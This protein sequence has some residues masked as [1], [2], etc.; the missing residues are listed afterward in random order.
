MIVGYIL[1]FSSLFVIFWAMIGYESSL[2]ILYA[3]FKKRKKIK[4]LTIKNVKVTLMI[5]AH[6]E[7]KVIKKKLENAISIK[8]PKEMLEILVTSDNSTD[9]TN[10]IILDFIKENPN[11]NIRL[12]EVKERKGKTNAQNEA[13]KTVNSEILV[14]TDANAMFDENAI[15]EL[16]KS[17]ED[18]NI[19]YVCGQL[20]YSNEDENVASKSESMYWKREL[21]TRYIESEL[22]TI[23]SGNGAIYACRND[24]YI[25]FD[26]IQSHDSAMPKHF[27]LNKMRAIYNPDA[28]AYEKAGESYQDEFKRKVRMN[29]NIIKNLF[30]PLKVLNFFKYGW[31]TYFYLGHRTTRSNLAISHIILLVTNIIL[32]INNIYFTAMLTIHLLFYLFAIIGIRIKWLIFRLPYYYTLTITAQLIGIFNGLTGK[33]KPFWEKAETTR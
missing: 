15:T 28:I 3:I 26:P 9:K 1:F 10:G 20:R 7:E 21:K 22:K 32:S 19:A 33:S 14:M 8:Y 29:R 13:Q 18:K 17:F 27:A 23:V 16:V 2:R 24:L 6:N 30:P 11:Y 4:T 5:V 25:D 12:F 31:Y